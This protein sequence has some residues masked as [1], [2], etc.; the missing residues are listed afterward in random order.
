MREDRPVLSGRRKAVFGLLTVGV[1]LGLLLVVF[2]VA[3]IVLR[4]AQRESPAPRAEA[5]GEFLACDKDAAVGWIFPPSAEGIFRRGAR[6]VRGRTNE[7]GLRSPPLGERDSALVR[8][9]VIG[10]SF[11]FGWGVAEAEAFPRRLEALLRARH[12]SRRIEVVNAGIPGYSL[13]QQRALLERLTVSFRVDA[14]IST[15]SL[16]NDVVDELRIRRYAPD[17]LL[18][19]QPRPLD[20]KSGLAGLIAKSRVLEWIDLRT[21]A[22]QFQ[23]ANVLPA[24]LDAAEESLDGIVTKCREE[25]IPVLFFLLPKRTEI[26]GAAPRRTLARW[27]TGSARRMVERATA[28]NAVSLVDVTPAI[29]RLERAAAGSAYLPDDPHW[30]AAGHEAVATAVVDA[31]DSLIASRPSWSS[32]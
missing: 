24:G 19:Y 11:V 8:I 31:V 16:S 21:R 28:R 26:E 12:P 23:I 7:W 2:A 29:E 17:R 6:S 27:M 15:F 5:A 25:G 30:T 18:A 14:V 3:E 4:F 32:R 22:L 20:P 10:D 1:G 9:L 13:W